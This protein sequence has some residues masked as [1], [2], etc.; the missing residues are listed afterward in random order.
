MCWF[1]LFYQQI[2]Y[3]SFA[4]PK[5][6]KPFNP[7]LMLGIVRAIGIVLFLFLDYVFLSLEYS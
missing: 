2:L 7:N 4:Y 1:L 6:I 3:I 5:S